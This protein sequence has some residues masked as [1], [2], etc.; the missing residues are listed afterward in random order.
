MTL[1]DVIDG[2]VV[3]GMLRPENIEGVEDRSA[4]VWHHEFLS[5]RR[6]FGPPCAACLIN[7]ENHPWMI[8]VM[9]EERSMFPWERFYDSGLTF[10]EWIDG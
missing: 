8:H 5:V 1:G 10:I 6:G 7:T 9:G 2:E 4:I 3:R